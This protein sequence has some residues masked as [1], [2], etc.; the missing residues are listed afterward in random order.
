[1][2]ATDPREKL[3]L[4]WGYTTRLAS[5]LGAVFDECPYEVRSASGS[6]GMCGCIVSLG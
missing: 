6:P 4:Y 3:G 5:G 1:M 2:A